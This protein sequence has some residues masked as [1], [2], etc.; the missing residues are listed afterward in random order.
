LFATQLRCVYYGA[1]GHVAEAARYRTQAER[2]LSDIGSLWQVETWEAAAS[3]LTN[4]IAMG[5]VV[6][7][8]RSLHQLEARSRSVSSLL[9]YSALASQALISVQ[10]DRRYLHELQALDCDAEPRAYVGWAATMS[11]AVRSYNQLGDFAGA[12]AFATRA[13]R[14]VSELD[15]EWATLFVPLDIQTAIAD[16]GL[17]EVDLALARLERSIARFADCDHALVQGLLH[18]ARAQICWEAGRREEYDASRAQAERWLRPTQAPALLAKCEQLASLVRSA[19]EDSVV[20]RRT[21]VEQDSACDE[22]ETVELGSRAWA[23]PSATSG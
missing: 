8:T 15:R 1:R 12:R 19:P 18:E 3:I 7:T 14:H 23:R 17:G 13:L 5:D 2:E 9:R 20:V 10:R 4:A 22:L 11:A 6:S 16:A 21:R